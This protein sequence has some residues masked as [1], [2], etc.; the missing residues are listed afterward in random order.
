MKNK[1][2]YL[3]L[4]AVALFA[5]MLFAN[6]TDVHASDTNY[7]LKVETTINNWQEGNGLI[8]VKVDENWEDI[9]FND[10][11][12]QYTKTVYLQKQGETTKHAITSSEYLSNFD[13]YFEN[14]DTVKLIEEYTFRS[15][16]SKLAVQQD[17]TIDSDDYLTLGTLDQGEA[18]GKWST[19]AE[20][21]RTYASSALSNY[22]G[23]NMGTLTAYYDG[24]Y[25]S[26]YK[27]YFYFADGNNKTT[28]YDRGQ[29]N[30]MSF[31]VYADFDVSG[32][33][34]GPDSYYWYVSPHTA[35]SF[36]NYTETSSYEVVSADQFNAVVSDD[37]DIY[38]CGTPQVNNA[39]T[40]FNYGTSWSDANVSSVETS[41]DYMYVTL[42]QSGD[43]SVTP[44]NGIFY[45]ILPFAVAGLVAIAGIVIL[46]KNS[47]K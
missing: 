21:Q 27:Y 12:F 6:T 26:A 42:T 22:N 8:F 30:L 40:S 17:F 28:T 44:P 10:G 36:G 4:F 41:G 43:F 29:I 19:G 9:S 18:T 5:I 34:V 20:W 39:S 31:R 32:N 13:G 7:T 16:G 3:I 35:N 46:K 47:I 45:N 15:T 14:G 25:E 33:L 1:K 37:F 11:Y 23:E 24:F 2:I 38:I